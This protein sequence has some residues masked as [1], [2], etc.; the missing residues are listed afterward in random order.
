MKP[1]EL[2]SVLR[3]RKQLEN[4]AATKLANAQRIFQHAEKK[5]EDA[6]A[7]Y[8]RIETKLMESQ[9]IGIDVDDLIRY[10][11]RLTWLQTNVEVLFKELQITRENVDKER[12]AVIHRSREKKVLEQLKEKQNKAYRLYIDKKESAQLD[13]I[14]VLSYGKKKNDNEQ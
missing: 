8:S 13:E 14:A 2:D 7:E 11:D 9:E 4:T 1:F 5:Y 3:Y 10:Q 12:E 6:S